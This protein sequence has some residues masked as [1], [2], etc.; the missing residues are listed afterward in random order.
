M[1]SL[2]QDLLR[3]PSETIVGVAVHGGRLEWTTCLRSGDGLK[4]TGSGQ[5]DLPPK[6]EEGKEAGGAEGKTVNLRAEAEKA[7]LK[8]E[9]IC[10][11]PS[12]Q[13]L[14]RV[15]SLP[16]V[17]D[18]E[19]RSMV[20]L[21]VDKF[22][23]FPVEST[24]ISHEVVDRKDGKSLVLVA[25]VKEEV[26]RAMRTVLEALG[27]VPAGLDAEVLGWW[28]L[29]KEGGHI[30][31]QGRQVVLIMEGALPV[32]IVFQ[33]GKPIG[34]RSL[35]ES[36]GLTGE[37]FEIETAR[38]VSYT[39][40]SMEMEHGSDAYT[41]QV[42]HRGE[43]PSGL[44]D[45]IKGE[46]SCEASLH[47]L[48]SLPPLSEGLARRMI[49]REAK[50]N[51]V[52][53]AWKATAESALFKKRMIAVAAL[54]GGVWLLTM[55]IFFGGLLFQQHRLTARKSEQAN[56]HKQAKEVADMRRR[57][58]TVERYM[59]TSHSVL[60]CLREISQRLPPGVLLASFSYIKGEELKISGEAGAVND[61]YTFRNQLDESK[62]FVSST[63][64][65]VRLDPRRNKQ[66]FDVDIKLPGGE[67]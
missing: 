11:L 8:G 25:A 54:A 37:D 52:P 55:L 64:N 10:G 2:I 45:K 4:K 65:N 30:R 6:P 43:A 66:L 15:V 41:V 47:S 61:I 34:I 3:L 16:D 35:G 7:G 22:S 46:C 1:K 32:A 14:L 28:Q 26:V 38:A 67:P 62:F 31:S 21:Q 56:W 50:L 24:V 44:A 9:I 5:I 20:E 59:D 19:L 39:L 60:E 33:E 17:P 63:L 57:V 48:D 51:L 40:M 49:A 36:E 18:D 13:L 27:L 12:E 53:A 58:L 29:L 42:W 23:P